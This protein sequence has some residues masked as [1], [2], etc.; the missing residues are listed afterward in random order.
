[1]WTLLRPRDFGGIFQ[2]W[3]CLFL[4][5]LIVGRHP[6]SIFGNELQECFKATGEK[7]TSFAV[8]RRWSSIEGSS[9]KQQ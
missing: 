4:H 7:Q 2:A 6:E 8:A 5:K 3:V 1:M 9:G